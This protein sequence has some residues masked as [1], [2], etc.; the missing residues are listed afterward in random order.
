MFSFYRTF[1]WAFCGCQREVMETWVRFWYIDYTCLNPIPQKL[2]P[3]SLVGEMGKWMRASQKAP[4][5]SPLLV[6]R[7]AV[8]TAPSVR[9]TNVCLMV[10]G[11]AWWVT[12][13]GK[14]VPLLS[15]PEQLRGT[16]SPQRWWGMHPSCLAWPGLVATPP[17]SLPSS[18]QTH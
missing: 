10:A 5:T 8:L 1:F 14:G 9:Q 11:V 16:K 17:P 2:N 12:G 6:R 3:G 7:G 13:L 15:Q 18:K 4:L